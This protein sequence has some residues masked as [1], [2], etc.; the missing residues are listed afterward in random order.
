[1]KTVFSYFRFV[2]ERKADCRARVLPELRLF[3][4]V[5]LSILVGITVAYRFA[6]P[7]LVDW[8]EQGVLPGAWWMGWITHAGKSDWILVST[9]SVLL[10]M[11]VYKFPKLSASHLIQWHHIFLKFYFAF[12]AV[13]FSGLIAIALKNIIGRARPVLFENQDF[14]ITN[15]FTDSYLYA[16]FPSGHST[17]MGA[18]IAVLYFV[19]PRLFWV[20]S[21][22][23]FLVALSRFVIGVHFPSDV[24]AGLALGIV[25]TW[26]YARVFARKRLL[27]EF[28]S[29]GQLRLRNS[30]VDRARRRLRKKSQSLADLGFGLN[31]RAVKTRV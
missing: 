3:F 20:L 15:P 5:C 18:M 19:S 7:L 2:S 23:A 8:M 13:A 16:S 14:W 29:E 27:F 4:A 12:T 9:G 10:F 30:V 28:N 21:P 17:T 24:V 25:F 31:K 22:I 11:S 26:L 1:M 6:D